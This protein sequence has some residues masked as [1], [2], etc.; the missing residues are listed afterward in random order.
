[1]WPMGLVLALVTSLIGFIFAAPG[2]T[3]IQGM[4]IS[5]EEN[6]QISI[7]GPLVNIVIGVLFLP[8]ALFSSPGSFLQDLGVIGAYI[9]IFLALFNLLPIGPLDGSKVWRWN[10]AIWA[11]TFIPTG[12]AFYY[13]FWA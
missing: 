12:I 1:M 3:Y 7:A 10:V 13:L 11:A 6:G 9:N 2:A 4:N 5:K 8:L